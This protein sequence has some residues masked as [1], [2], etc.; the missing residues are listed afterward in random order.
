MKHLTIPE[1]FAENNDDLRFYLASGRDFQLAYDSMLENEKWILETQVPLMYR[2][3]EL[4][5]YL[6]Q[7]IVYGY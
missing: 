4:K 1:C 5:H 3:A 2:Y 7:G 6:D